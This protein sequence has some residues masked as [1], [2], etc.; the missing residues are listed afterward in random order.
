MINF[1]SLSFYCNT[2]TFENYIYKLRKYG[3]SRDEVL[4]PLWNFLTSSSVPFLPT[5]NLIYY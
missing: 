5:G 4:E 2:N 1:L 3:I